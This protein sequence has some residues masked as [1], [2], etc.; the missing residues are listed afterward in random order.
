MQ[1]ITTFKNISRVERQEWLLFLL[2]VGPNLF[3]FS[4]FSFWPLI[5]NVHLS[6]S[7]WDMLAPVKTWVGLANYQRLFANPE[8]RLIVWN[9]FVFTGASVFLT[10]LLGLLGALLLNQPLKGRDFVRTALFAPTVL[11]GAA[12][13]IVWI[14]IFDPR[15]GLIAALLGA[16]HLTSPNW[17]TDP[18]WAMPAIIIVFTWKNLGYS[19]VIILAGLKAIPA[20]LYEAARVDGAGGWQRF[21]NVTLPGLSP[22]MFFL[23]LTNTLT[24]FQAFD[25]IKTM[26]DGGPVNAT[27]TL[28]FYLYE[29]GFIAFNSGYAGVAATLLFVIMLVFTLIQMRYSEQHVHYA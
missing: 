14:Y 19:L 15:F 9:T 25:I 8:F 17:L 6:F 7:Q 1:R 5:F 18:V 21:W 26:T 13:G 27:N 3:L 12:I 20:E 23:L 11:S 16:V 2:L 29:Q 10:T 24:S 4:I 28:I 22:V